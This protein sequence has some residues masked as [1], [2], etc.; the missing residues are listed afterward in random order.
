MEQEK[1]FRAALDKWGAEAQ[2]LMTFEEIAELQDALCKTARGRDNP[3]HIAE[4]IA[5]VQIML[6]QMAVLFGI[7]STVEEYREQKLARLAKRLGMEER[8]DDTPQESGEKRAP[9]PPGFHSFIKG[10]FG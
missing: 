3:Y 8:P 1:I 10:R 6:G 5:D 2:T 4:E 7:E 9:L